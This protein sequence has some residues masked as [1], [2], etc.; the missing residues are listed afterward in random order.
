MWPIGVESFREFLAREFERSGKPVSAAA[1]E[2]I[3]GVAG[4]RSADVQQR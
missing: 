2:A 3:L 4:E 1:L